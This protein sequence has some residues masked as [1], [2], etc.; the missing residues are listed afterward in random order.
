MGENNDGQS[1]M[2]SPSNFTEYSNPHL[3]CKIRFRWFS[4][5]QHGNAFVEISHPTALEQQIFFHCQQA[6]L[7]D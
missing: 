1:P 7:V 4:V 6:L 5:G 2:S 3:I